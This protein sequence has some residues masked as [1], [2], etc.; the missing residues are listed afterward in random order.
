MMRTLTVFLV[1]AAFAMSAGAAEA[2]KLSA[3]AL[4]VAAVGAE[5]G[6]VLP[7]EFRVALYENLISQTRKTGRF[8]HV[9]RDGEKPADPAN[10][11]TLRCMV[12]GFKE[13][14]ARKR[15]VTT[16][17]GATKIK[18]HVEFVDGTGKV[19]L[20]R[21]VDGNVYFL[22]E[23]LRATFNFSKSVAKIVKESFAP[24]STAT[25]KK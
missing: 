8:A 3:S 15:E 12:T 5:E 4:Q 23:N 18:V 2:P 7:L 21:E 20:A 6:V 13:G 24:P 22:G 25:A 17:A 14:S 11:V 10:T 19:L 1:V 16:V 9:Y